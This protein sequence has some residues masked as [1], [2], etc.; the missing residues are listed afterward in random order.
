MQVLSLHPSIEQVELEAR[1]CFRDH[2][3]VQSVQRLLESHQAQL[4]SAPPAKLLETWNWKVISKDWLMSQGWFGAFLF[5]V[6]SGAFSVLPFWLVDLY[7]SNSHTQMLYV[8][9]NFNNSECLSMSLLCYR[10][11][12]CTILHTTQTTGS[13]LLWAEWKICILTHR[14]IGG[15]RRAWG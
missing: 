2:L 14:E 10:E 12:H 13:Y 5:S 15:S 4:H 6:V 1:E 8:L 7:V 11:K 3:P 9:L